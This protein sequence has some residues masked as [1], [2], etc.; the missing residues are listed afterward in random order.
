M[1]LTKRLTFP[2]IDLVYY[3][4]EDPEEDPEEDVD[5]ELEDD[6]E[7]IFAYEVEGEKTPPPGY[8]SSDLVSSESES[9]DEKV[10]VAP[11]ATVGTTTQKPYA[12]HDFSRDLFEVGESPSA[13]DSSN[14]D[15]LAPWALREKEKELPNHDLENIERALG[16]FLERMSVLESRENAIL[17]KRLAETETKLV[18][19]RMKRDTAERRIMPIKAMSEARMR[20]II[21]DQVTTSMAEFTAN[22]N[23]ETGGA[24]ADGIGAGGAGVGGAGVDGAGADGTGVGVARPAAPEIT[25]CTYIT[26]MKS[27]IDLVDGRISSM[28]IGAANGTL[29]TE[30]RKWMSKEFCPQSVLQRLEQ[31]LYNLKLKGTNIDG[32]TNRFHELALL[33]PRMV[34]PKQ[35]KVEQYIRELSKNIHGD[36]TSSMPAGID[37]AV[38]M[39]YQLMGQIIQDKTDEVF[40]GE[41]RKGEG[42]HGGRGD[43]RRNYNRRQNQR[44]VNAGAMTNA[45]PNENE[46]V[47][48]ARIRS[49]VGI[50]GNVGHRTRYCP[51]L[52]KNGQSGNN[53]KAVYKLRAVDAQQDSKVV[54]CTFLLN[55]RYATA[56]F[57]SGADKSFVSINFS[58][59]I[60]IEPIDLD[61]S[62]EVELADGKVESNSDDTGG[63]IVGEA[64]GACSGGIA[65]S[66]VASYAC[67]T[68]IYGSSCK[69]EKTSVAKRYL[70]K[71]FEESGEVFP[72]VAGK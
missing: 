70:V 4:E 38:R 6:A 34:E 66:L 14:V 30:V 1:I 33:C 51:K 5:I 56:I 71:S 21:R 3:D 31:E 43:N 28:G 67:M 58:T 20:E 7:L 11:E 10:D 61:T 2:T 29:W 32:Y 40:E 60:D 19:A 9:D 65:N 27:C 68:S 50:V 69:G 64:I 59:L 48:S 62:Y 44:R 35:V 41:I 17:K 46:F 39:A 54:T 25:G 42:D 49:M 22:M 72:D 23:R 53:H 57:D 37:E 18:W 24:R 36:V 16:N 55:N 12:I 13:R 47:Q 15:E 45:A 8:V 63:I 52:K 26:F